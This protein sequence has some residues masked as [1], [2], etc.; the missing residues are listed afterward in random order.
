MGIDLGYN[1]NGQ[2]AQ[3]RL[4]DKIFASFSSPIN[5]MAYKK[6]YE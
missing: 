5:I 2:T 3:N 4:T 6:I 1:D